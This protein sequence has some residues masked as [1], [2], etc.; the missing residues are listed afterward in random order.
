MYSTAASRNLSVSLDSRMIYYQTGYLTFGG[1]LCTA[2]MRLRHD[3]DV[4]G[5]SL[6][7]DTNHVPGL[8]DE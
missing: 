2:V 3:F 8:T 5:E 7:I 4:I 1:G 6:K